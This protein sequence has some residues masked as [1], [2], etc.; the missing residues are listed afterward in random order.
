MM[1]IIMPQNIQHGQKSIESYK[2]ARRQRH[3]DA[4]AWRPFSHYIGRHNVSC[5]P[6][7]L[8]VQPSQ[9]RL[10]EHTVKWAYLIKNEP[11]DHRHDEARDGMAQQYNGG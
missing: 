11:N 10:A 7:Q 9:N 4:M 6:V 8:S 2:T 1:T 3:R 5:P